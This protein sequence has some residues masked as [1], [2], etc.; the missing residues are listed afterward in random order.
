MFPAFGDYDS[1]NF[2]PEYDSNNSSIKSPIYINVKPFLDIAIIFF[3]AFLKII[4][5]LKGLLALERQNKEEIWF[6]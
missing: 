3:R 4:L 2:F 5:V 1:N 6:K